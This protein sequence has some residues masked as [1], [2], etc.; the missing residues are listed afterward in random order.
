[1]ENSITN[2]ASVTGTFDSLP[3][4][5]TSEAVITPMT[6]DLTIA[7]T[8]DKQVWSDGL[9]TYTVTIANANTT[10]DYET[11]V[12]TDVIDPSKAVLVADSVTLNGSTV[13]YTYDDVTGTLSVNIGTI[14]AAGNGI[15]TFQVNKA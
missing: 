1:M 12:F 14:D 4:A 9:L 7:K 5:L 10:L 6:T 3:T 15:I 11:V 2:I 13:A 8:A